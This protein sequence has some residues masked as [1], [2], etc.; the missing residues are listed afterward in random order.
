MINNWAM[1]LQYP[2]TGDDSDQ[3]QTEHLPLQESGEEDNSGTSSLGSPL[4]IKILYFN[5]FH[6]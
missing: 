3:R 4:A 6:F 1:S 2:S 5:Q